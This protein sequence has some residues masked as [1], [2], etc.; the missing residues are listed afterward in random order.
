ML[1]FDSGLANFNTTAQW[2]LR[3]LRADL[4][5]TEDLLATSDW[6]A[7][8]RLIYEEVAR[9]RG[10]AADP[11]DPTRPF[12]Q[13]AKL[14]PPPL[15]D[16]NYQTG[17]GGGAA[18]TFSLPAH[19]PHFDPDKMRLPTPPVWNE[20]VET[21]GGGN[22]ADNFETRYGPSYLPFVSDAADMVGLKSVL[23]SSHIAGR[24]VFV[25][26]TWHH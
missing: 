13:W 20:A 2:A 8:A 12:L 3:R 23:T 19:L 21:G 15:H 5:A 6:L 4:E 25:L 10:L 11:A 22:D 17:G 1:A 9:L 14:L 26:T 16:A 7:G 24:F 18:A